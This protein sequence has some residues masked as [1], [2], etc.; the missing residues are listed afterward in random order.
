MLVAS[1]VTG[2][3]KST[4]PR[5]APP[6]RAGAIDD[7]VTVGSALDQ[8]LLH[9]V[10]ALRQRELESY[11]GAILA[12]V[13]EGA[14]PVPQRWTL[15]LLDTSHVSI[16]SGPGGFVYVTRGLLAWLGNEAELAAA[17]AHEIAHVSRRHW[18]GQAEFLIAHGIED[19]DLDKLERKA[20]LELLSRLRAEELEAD[21]L[22]LGYL[23]RAG[24]DRRGLV[25][26][27]ELFS[28][29]EREAGG[30]RIPAALRTHPDAAARLRAIGTRGRSGGTLRAREYLT[31]IEGLVFG[32]DPRDGYLFGERYVVPNA[33]FELTLPGAW[34]ARLIGRDLMAALPGRGTVALVARSEHGTLQGTE[35]ALNPG[36]PFVEEKRAEYRVR[37]AR[38]EAEGGLVSLTYIFDTP[39]APLVLAVVLPGR[40]E[41]APEIESLLAGARRIQDPA[42]ARVGPL[43]VRVTTLGTS[44]T[45]RKLFESNPPHTSLATFALVN[46]VAPDQLL[47]TGSIVK[48][49]DP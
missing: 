3:T 11:V 47:P 17:L 40:E 16:R 10:P 18:R 15:R 24:Y 7:D 8:E 48:R 45:L 22:A 23:E 13:A 46:G 32:E 6:S 2:C 36:A 28:D 27:I 39:G 14:A 31:R 4:A 33:D 41:H 42:L 37:S 34:R 35:R 1:A 38:T 21:Q 19:G 43:R 25:R 49:I 44:T 9:D 20:R 12:K 5:G 30:V 26:V 29:L